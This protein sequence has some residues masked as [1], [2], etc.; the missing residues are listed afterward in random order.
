[1]PE[2]L[3]E[4]KRDYERSLSKIGTSITG[5]SS[6]GRSRKPQTMKMKEMLD[7]NELEL[8]LQCELTEL[9]TGIYM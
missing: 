5:S 7:I 9:E 6:R 8:K 2:Y 3:Q 1:M 4:L